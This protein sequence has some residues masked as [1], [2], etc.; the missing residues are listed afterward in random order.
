MWEYCGMARTE[1]GL[2]KALELI[3]ALREE[4]WRT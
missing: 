4:F 2:K 3:P 1:E